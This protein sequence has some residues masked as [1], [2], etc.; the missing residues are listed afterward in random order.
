MPGVAGAT[1]VAAT[2][3]GGAALLASGTVVTWGTNRPSY[4]GWESFTWT[5][6]AVPVAGLTG[7]TSIWAGGEDTGVLRTG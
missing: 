7:V 6:T 1:E 2:E 4:R 3:F 5:M